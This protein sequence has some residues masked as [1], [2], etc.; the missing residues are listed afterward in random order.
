[1]SNQDDITRVETAG[2]YGIPRS[3]WPAAKAA[4]KNFLG[5][6]PEG[7]TLRVHPDGRA[8]IVSRNDKSSVPTDRAPVS[9]GIQSKNPAD[10]AEKMRGLHDRNPRE[11]ALL[12]K[13]LETG[14]HGMDPAEVNWCASFVSATLHHAGLSDIPQSQGGDVA[15]SYMNWGLP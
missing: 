6:H 3:E 5:N 11:R 2:C 9:R 4:I 12:K 13:Y 7:A 10:I 15:L 8:K 14:G 1:M